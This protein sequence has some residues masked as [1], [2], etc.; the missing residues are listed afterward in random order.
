MHLYRKLAPNPRATIAT[1]SIERTLKLAESIGKH[2]EVV[3]LEKPLT[4]LLVYK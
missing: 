3:E 2:K 4:R 1:K